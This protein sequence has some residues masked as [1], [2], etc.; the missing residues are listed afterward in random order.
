[1]YYR[2]IKK[3]KVEIRPKACDFI[4]FIIWSDL[5]LL[6]SKSVILI[7]FSKLSKCL[8]IY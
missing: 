4:N 3:S 7:I 6:K 2:G 8:I 1:M 5:V